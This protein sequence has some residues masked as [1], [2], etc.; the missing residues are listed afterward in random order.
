VEGRTSNAMWV[1]DSNRTTD[2]NDKEQLT[3]PMS[4]SGLARKQVSGRDKT[5]ARGARVAK[6]VRRRAGSGPAASQITMTSDE[7]KTLRAKTQ[8]SQE[9]LARLVGTSWVT[10]SRWEREKIVPGGEAETRLARLL[11]LVTRVGKALP[12]HRIY[13]F[14]ETPHPLFRG[15]RP[16]ELLSSDYAFQDLLTFVDSAKSG[17]MA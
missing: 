9:K 7:I 11:E 5:R 12:A 17:D 16:V 8:L 3:K 13:D 10:I 15:H 14:L 2:T 4:N 1:H 6:E